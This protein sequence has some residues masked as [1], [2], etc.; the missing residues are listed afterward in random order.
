MK[1]AILRNSDVMEKNGFRIRTQRPKIVWKQ[2]VYFLDKKLT[3]FC[4]PV[5]LVNK[6]PEGF[7]SCKSTYKLKKIS[8]LKIFSRHKNRKKVF[9]KLLKRFFFLAKLFQ[10]EFAVSQ[11][12]NRRWDESHSY[13]CLNN[14]N[15]PLSEKSESWISK[16]T[17]I[18]LFW[19]SENSNPSFHSKMVRFINASKL[20]NIKLIRK[21]EI[22]PK[23]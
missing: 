12:R 23:L 6:K 9:H 4:W 15:T 20:E 1:L 11:K 21:I 10:R 22:P 14:E 17:F 2:V 19:D 5:E 8:F 13:L 3:E 18:V 7:Y 16:L